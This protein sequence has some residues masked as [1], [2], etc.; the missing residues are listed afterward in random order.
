MSNEFTTETQRGP[1]ATKKLGTE[2]RRH[3]ETRRKKTC[4]SRNKRGLSKT[5][6]P[7]AKKRSCTLATQRLHRGPRSTQLHLARHVQLSKARS[8]SLRNKKLVSDSSEHGAVGK[9]GLPPLL[10]SKAT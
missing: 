7:S 5:G 10:D 9:G 3:G 4:P 1:A 6:K 2:T 8:R